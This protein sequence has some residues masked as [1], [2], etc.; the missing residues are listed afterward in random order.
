MIGT[1]QDPEH[2]DLHLLWHYRYTPW[3]LTSRS[4]S[5]MSRLTRKGC[6]WHFRSNREIACQ[7]LM[8][9]FADVT[10]RHMFKWLSWCGHA[11]YSFVVCFVGKPL[12]QSFLQFL[13]EENPSRFDQVTT[14]WVGISRN[15]RPQF[16]RW[17]GG[18]KM[19]VTSDFSGIFSNG[20]HWHTFRECCFLN[21][22]KSE[23]RK[24]AIS[25][26]FAWAGSF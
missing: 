18:T 12:L 2:V 19:P 13:F 1:L 4:T 3:S 20:F 22:E 6:L 16:C 8:M 26:L 23:N 7:S 10:R 15:S 5:Y 21:M 24:N 9:Q 25:T 11:C 17:L 14:F